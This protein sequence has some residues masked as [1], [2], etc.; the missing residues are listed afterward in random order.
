[1]FKI[2]TKDYRLNRTLAERMTAKIAI[3]FSANFETLIIF[4]SAVK[5]T[6][7]YDVYLTHITFDMI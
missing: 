2:F 1:M 5:K 7:L 4:S 6:N 3:N